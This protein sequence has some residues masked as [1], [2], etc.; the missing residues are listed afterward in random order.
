[1]AKVQIGFGAVIGDEDLAMLKGRHR[2]GIDVQIGVQL[3]QAHRIA[4]RLQQRAQ[5][6]R[7]EAFAKR[8]HHAAGDE[9]IA[10]HGGL[11][12]W[13]RTG[14]SHQRNRSITGVEE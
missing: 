14:D 3:A 2:A 11:P 7:G 10:R 4:A 13:L 9:N 12:C 8:R 1:M 6:G 5:G